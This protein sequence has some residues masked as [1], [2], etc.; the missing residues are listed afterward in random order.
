MVKP[1]LKGEEKKEIDMSNDFNKEQMNIVVVGHVDHGKSTVIGRLMAD[2]GSLPDGKLEQVRQNC[3]RNSKPFEYAFL[4]DA[5][6]DEQSQGI[7]I[8]SARCFFNTDK[9]HYIIIDAPGHI[10]FLKNMIT[11]AA[12]AEAALLIID[13]DEGVQEN[14][15]RHG[16]MLS[17][18]GIR[19][20]VVCVNKMDLVDYSQ[21][22]FDAIQKEYSA[23]LKEINVEPQ[24][25][26]PISARE[27]DNIASLSKNMSWY[28]GSYVLQSID[29]FE[30]EK[31]SL[32]QPFRFPVQDIYKFT[33]EDDDRRI[34]AGRIESGEIKAG[35]DVIFLP[36]QKTSTIRAVEGFNLADSKYAYSGQSTGFTLETQIYMK[37]GE[38]MCKV[39]DTLPKVGSRFRAN[40]FW[41][42]RQPMIKN[43]QYKIKIGTERI[44]VWLDEIH[45][46]LDASELS[47]VTNKDQID[48]HDVCDCTLQTFKPIAFDLT[49]DIA[50]TS[51]FVI[52]DDY[53]IS[54]GGIILEELGSDNK[55]LDDYITHREERWERGALTPAKRRQRFGHASTLVVFTGPEGVGK[56]ALAKSLEEQLFSD[57][58]YSYYLGLSNALNHVTSKTGTELD[59][60]SLLLQLGEMAHLFTDAG[61]I[62][63]TSVSQTD[64]YELDMLRKLNSPSELLLVNVGENHFSKNKADLQIDPDS[65]AEGQLSDVVAL[66]RSKNVISDYMI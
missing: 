56:E 10:E 27:G 9:R 2:T 1:P 39:G 33:E 29:A 31:E 65:D 44:S 4:L 60:A 26:I 28:E 36:S 38:I 5:L 16:Y 45:H 61:L 32:E 18:L 52:V 42:R 34:F 24:A 17:M 43:K 20:I 47:T 62:L 14:S 8:D 3:K 49:T 40:I 21:A 46:I 53:E 19:Q 25:F 11:G 64:D 58:F 57:G 12:R 22:K 7:T 35:D 23:F 30:K 15:R 51:R 54:A 50:V 41:L 37:P 48:R 6:K 13:A 63:I 55:R 59:R 66:L